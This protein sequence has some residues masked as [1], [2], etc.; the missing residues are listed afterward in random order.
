MNLPLPPPAK[1]FR[2]FRAA[3]AV[4][5]CANPFEDTPTPPPVGRWNSEKESIQE[6][7]HVTSAASDQIYCFKCRSKTDTLE[8]QEV[9]LKNGR[10]AVTSQC[11]VCGTKKFRMGAARK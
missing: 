8:A 3:L 9:V 2:R 6:E 7:Q 4:A 11:T 1:S 10:P 5:E